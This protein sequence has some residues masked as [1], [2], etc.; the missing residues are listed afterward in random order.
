M[1]K[2]LLVFLC[3]NTLINCQSVSKDTFSKE[4]LNDQ[5]ININGDSISFKSILDKHAGKDILIDVWASWCK[6][7]IESLPKLKE[8]QKSYP[9]LDYIF[10]SLDKSKSKWL[11]GIDHYK[12]TGEHYFMSS[13][14]KGPMGEFLNLNW[15]PRFLLVNSKGQIV[16]FN[17]IKPNDKNLL[18][19][20]K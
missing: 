1:R 17:A 12:L 10:L 20:L 3:V 16:V 15:I 11:R 14:R 9:K 5:F 6:D 4:A 13:G 8:L 2:I 19:N 7:C 18:I